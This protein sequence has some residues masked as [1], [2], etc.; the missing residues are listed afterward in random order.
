MSTQYLK[1][2]AER[3]IKTFCQALAATLTAGAVDLISVPWTGALSA[4]GLAALLSVLTSVASAGFG[5]RET[6]SLVSN[7]EDGAEK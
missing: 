3:A 7:K 4:A 5:D 6:P 2:L 1:D